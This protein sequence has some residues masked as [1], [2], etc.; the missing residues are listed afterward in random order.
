MKRELIEKLIAWKQNPRRKPL[1]LKGTRQVGKTYL[2]KHFGEQ[3]FP[4]FFYVNF[5]KQPDLMG[6]FERDYNPA[7]LL[8]ELSFHFK[9]Q[10]NAQQDLL[11]FDEIQACPKAI[12]SLKYFAEDMPEL[13][14]CAVGSLL[15]IY[16]NSESFP[17]GKVEWLNMY[18]LTFKEFLWGIGENQLADHLES[19]HISTQ[20]PRLA[21]QQLWEQ[22]KI[23]FIV[24]GLP[25]VVVQYNMSKGALYDAFHQVRETQ[26]NLIKDYYAD[27]AKHSGKVN[28]MHIDRVWRAVPAQLARVQDASTSRFKFKDI[29]SGIDRYS[30]LA[31]VIDWL[32]NT[33]L[34]IKIHIVECATLPLLAYTKES[35]FKLC[36]FDVGI[37]GAMSDL[38]PKII[39]NNLYGSYKGYFAENFVVQEFLA[40]NVEHLYSW[41][42][43]TA[44]IEFLREINGD[45]IPVE[46]KS[47]S[48]THAKSLKVFSDKYQPP[49]QIILSAKSKE[50]DR[51]RKIYHLP[52]YLAGFLE[53]II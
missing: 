45:I 33:G 14:L 13:A 46:V 41:Q 15:G 31:N 2:L 34:L 48:V 38:S 51:K 8:T 53:K 18:P 49:Y 21:H 42:R 1:I 20:I 37:L 52:L 40:S 27:I 6:I 29:I 26:N 43:G 30:R 9:Q 10:I 19:I 44:E 50:M 3:H 12:T 22:L 24:G 11:I 39:L 7:R 32:I 5:E 47:G 25:E 23:Y 35:L 4:R 16:L 28:A 36:M 17:V